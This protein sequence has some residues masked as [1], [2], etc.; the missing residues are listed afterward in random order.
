MKSS[1]Q[2]L[3]KYLLHK[4][5]ANVV[6]TRAKRSAAALFAIA[7]TAPVLH[8]EVA[9]TSTE[10]HSSSML[11]DWWN[12][13]YMTGNWFGLRDT[14][15]DNGLTFSGRYYGA[16]FGVVDSQGGSRGFWDQGLEFGSELNFGKALR[17]E[18]L[19]GLKAFGLVRWRDDREEADPNKFVHASSMFNPSNWISGVQWRLMTFGL[20]YKT[21]DLLPVK[22]M[23]SLRGGWLMPQ[24]EFIDQPLSKLF[25][26]TAVNSSKG[27]GGNI[28]FSS[29]FSTW[30]GTLQIK[31]VEWHYAKV[32]LFMAYPQATASTNHG[33]AMRGF[34][35][36]PSK[37][38]LMVMGELGFTPKIGPSKLPGKYAF[39]SY[40]WGNER[41]SFN[42]SSHYGQY[43]FYWQ[44]DQMIFREPS[45]A[46]E[47]PVPPSGKNIVDSKSFKTPVS[48][49][50]P[51][52]SDQG[53]SIFNLFSFAP[54]YNNLFPF[55]FH[56]GLVYKG[57][58]P[59]RDED[60]TMFSLALGSYSYYSN[61]ARRQRGRD[62]Q[63]Y[64]MLLEFGYRFQINEWAFLQPFAQYVIRPNGTDNVANATILGFATGVTF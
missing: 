59:G 24:R 4:S 45:P 63:D 27:I 30:G 13:K 15:K 36:D 7:L 21:G 60:Q 51:K 53:L 32:G 57:L 50:K 28:P 26:N 48:T 35:P 41:N 54:K 19:E 22:D 17:V 5:L 55:Y 3:R 31:P 52:L 29:S 62:W 25:L 20:E 11:S 56:S 37:N 1:P 61:L 23:I 12:G 34:G 39:G 2:P 9:S 10:A 33:L 8:A 64:T 6:H 46:V 44:A 47:E 14:L 40:F 16:F 42:G 49:A 58:I 38:G 43:G 18:N